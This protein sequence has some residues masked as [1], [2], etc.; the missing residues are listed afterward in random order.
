MTKRHVVISP[1]LNE[2]VYRFRVMNWLFARLEQGYE[3][4]EAE[5]WLAPYLY[6]VEGDPTLSTMFNANFMVASPCAKV[7]K[8][9][10][11]QAEFLHW[12]SR[13]YLKDKVNIDQFITT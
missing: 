6:L 8:L 9:S 4:Y 12:V 2:I 11:K 7:T 13:K 5:E 1:L 3:D 10:V